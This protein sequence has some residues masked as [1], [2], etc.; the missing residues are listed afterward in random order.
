MFPTDWVEDAEFVREEAG[1][2]VFRIALGEVAYPERRI[3]GWYTGH[4]GRRQ[5]VPRPIV[6]IP[7]EKYTF[8]ILA[9]EFWRSLE[10]SRVRREGMAP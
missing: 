6:L 4:R 10:R 1:S 5:E 7:G 3:F 2:L 9:D 8:D